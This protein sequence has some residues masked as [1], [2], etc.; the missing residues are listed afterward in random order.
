MADVITRKIWRMVGKDISRLNE[1]FVVLISVLMFLFYFLFCSILE[2]KD[3]KSFKRDIVI[4][5]S[6]PIL[7]VS[8]SFL[9]NIVPSGVPYHTYTYCSQKLDF[10]SFTCGNEIVR[11]P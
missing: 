9:V 4:L 1:I 6:F 7:F 8:T 3:D 2:R 11:V 5:I 10:F